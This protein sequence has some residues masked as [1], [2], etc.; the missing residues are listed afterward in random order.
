MIVPPGTPRIEYFQDEFWNPNITQLFVS[1]T[2]PVYSPPVFTPQCP[3][4]WMRAGRIVSK[5]C[6]DLPN[7]GSCTTNSSRCTCAA[8]RG[9]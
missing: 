5:Q 2:P 4:T 6:P 9:A 1:A 7:G 8:N 3:F